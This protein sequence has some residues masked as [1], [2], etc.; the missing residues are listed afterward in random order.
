MTD[1]REIQE[2]FKKWLEDPDDWKETILSLQSLLNN[3][4]FTDN[5]KSGIGLLVAS[6]FGTMCKKCDDWKVWNW[7]NAYARAYLD[8]KELPVFDTRCWIEQCD[9]LLSI[10]N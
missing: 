2:L 6:V 4:C 7:M 1:N 10:P 9:G 5:A 3:R 8:N